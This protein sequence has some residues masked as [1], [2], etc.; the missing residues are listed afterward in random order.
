MRV[1]KLIGVL[2][3]AGCTGP[4]APDVAVCRDY[5]HRVCIPPVCG[6]VTP[7]VPVG[8][9]CE[10]TFLTNT[11]CAN[12]TFKFT[13]PNRNDF[14]N[15]RAGLLNAG[16]DPEQPPDCQDVTDSFDNCPAVVRFLQGLK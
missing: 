12:D 5:I 6:D 9:D 11:G 8:Q 7:L 4:P 1:V 14:I 2:V 16:D 15:C 3:V 10:T 13:T